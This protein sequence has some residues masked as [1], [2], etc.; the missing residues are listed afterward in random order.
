MPP[1]HKI[2]TNIMIEKMMIEPYSAMRRSY[3]ADGLSLTL[4]RLE[5]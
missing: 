2:K 4:G 1:N 5:Y 3:I